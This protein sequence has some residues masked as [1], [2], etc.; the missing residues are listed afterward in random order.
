MLPLTARSEAAQ[1]Q[2]NM[3]ARSCFCPLCRQHLDKVQALSQPQPGAQALQFRRKH[4]QSLL[5]QYLIILAKNYICYWRYPQYN[6]VS[7]C[8]IAALPITPCL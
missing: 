7:F 2:S 4:A 1:A 8:Q 5:Q 6:A 3:L